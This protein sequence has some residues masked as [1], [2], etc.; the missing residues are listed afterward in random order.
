MSIVTKLTWIEIRTASHTVSL[1]ITI[2]Y[3][4]NGVKIP[5]TLYVLY[6]HT[7]LYEITYITKYFR[8]NFHFDSIW[9]SFILLCFALFFF[10]VSW[11]VCVRCESRICWKVRKT[12]RK[13]V[14]VSTHVYTLYTYGYIPYKYNILLQMMK[15]YKNHYIIYVIINCGVNKIFK[16]TFI[17]TYVE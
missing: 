12:E 4:E 5:P 6:L 17:Y 14:Y 2:C 15:Y 1:L 7:T 9:I 16:N 8:K 13:Y 3:N 11:W 10:I